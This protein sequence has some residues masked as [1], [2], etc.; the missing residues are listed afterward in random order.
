MEHFVCRIVIIREW[1]KNKSMLNLAGDCLVNSSL[2]QLLRV[3]KQQALPSCSRGEL[4]GM[5]WLIAPANLY[6]NALDHD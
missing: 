1:L 3:C 4:A 6:W 2:E 5:H